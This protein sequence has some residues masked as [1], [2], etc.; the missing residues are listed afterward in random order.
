MG[1]GLL[2]LLIHLFEVVDWVLSHFGVQS[3]DFGDDG[4]DAIEPG[5]GLRSD[6]L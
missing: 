6:R 3:I 2:H 4:P 1:L 5:L